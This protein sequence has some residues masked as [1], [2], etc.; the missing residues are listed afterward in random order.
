MAESF[1]KRRR[2]ERE[3]ELELDQ[4]RRVA[5]MAGKL[6][7]LEPDERRPWDS[8]AA[9]KYVADLFLGLENLCKRRYRYLDRHIPDG[10]ESHT[11]ILADFLQEPSLG[12]S[13]DGPLAERLKRYL[14]FRHRFSHG[15]GYEVNWEIVE[16]PLQLLPETVDVLTKMWREWVASLPTKDE[17]GRSR[18]VQAISR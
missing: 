10:P 6:A 7:E 16:E 12:G 1:S 8:A 11:Q 9:A 5:E 18:C 15:Y 14:R 4:L 13:L 3:I 17:P 2:L